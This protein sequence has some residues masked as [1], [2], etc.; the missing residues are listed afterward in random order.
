MRTEP[1]APKPAPQPA[2]NP[3]RAGKSSRDPQEFLA[4]D[5]IRLCSLRARCSQRCGRGVGQSW[6]Y[7]RIGQASTVGALPLVETDLPFVG[8]RR[9]AGDMERQGEMWRGRCGTGKY[10]WG[11]AVGGDR[12]PFR[13]SATPRGR[14][15]DL[16]QASTVGAL[17]LVETDL[18]FVGPQR[19]AEPA[20][21]SLRC[22]GVEGVEQASTVGALPLVETDLPFVDPRRL[23]E[24]ANQSL[25]RIRR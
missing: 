23:A 25:R 1:L 7:G 3:A 20:N 9:L 15:G 12:P 10:C 16:G 24:P 2:I 22:G 14:Y 19:L 18:P 5:G 21:Q 8:P 17:P 11:V 13:R 4:C 6:T